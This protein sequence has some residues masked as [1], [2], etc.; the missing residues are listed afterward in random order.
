MKY[1]WQRRLGLVLRWYL[2]VMRS[3]NCATSKISERA[4]VAVKA[5]CHLIFLD[6][7]LPASILI[8]ERA[9]P[10]CPICR[11]KLCQMSGAEL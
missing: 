3:G 2:A 11:L 6:T 8:Q 1:L 4:A 9:D 7:A 10:A 5:L